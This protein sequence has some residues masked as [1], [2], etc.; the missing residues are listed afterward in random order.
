MDVFDVSFVVDLER[1]ILVMHS[2][3]WLTSMEL[4]LIPN[5]SLLYLHSNDVNSLILL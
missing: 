2:F 4:I 1:R 5:C 3:C